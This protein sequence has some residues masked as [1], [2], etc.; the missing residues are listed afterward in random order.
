VERQRQLAEQ[1]L[2]Q[3]RA[4]GADAADVILGEGTDFSVTVR[5]GEVE[6]LEDAGSKALGLRVFVG[7]RTANSYTSDFSPAAL[8]ELVRETVE[9]ARVTGEDPAAGL[10]DEVVPAEELDL[11]LFDPSPAALPTAERIDWARRAEAA[12]LQASPEITNSQGGSYSSGEDVL[13]LGNTAGFLGSYRTSSV[14]FSV[15]PVAERDGRMERDY[16]Y[17]AGRGL[18]ELPSPEEVGRIA[19]ERTLR[20]LGARQVATAEVPVVFDPETAAELLGHVFRALSGY[21]VFRSATFLKDSL[22][23]VVASPLVTVVDEG[24]RPRGLGSRPFDGEG[25]PTRRNV[26][27]EKGVLRHF[28]CDS[29]S[30]RKIGARPTG[31]ARRGVAG[32]PTV[33]SSNLYLE[34]GPAAPEQILGE[35][36]RGLYVTDLI[37]FGVDLV[38]GDFSQGAVGHWIEKGRLVHPVSEV[39]IAGNLRQ[40]LPDIDAVGSDLVFRGSSAAPTLRV[41]KMTVSGS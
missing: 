5:K 15:V 33:G 25:L 29:Y 28:L 26:P 23:E 11:G 30:A 31:S 35:V 39:T 21:A 41:K 32:G 20:R 12:A 40:M 1:L 13:V 8:A 18:S 22:G 10:P 9:M 2:R 17:A 36:E 4:A 27:I 3:A 24:R 37:G 14:S 6:T 19:A 7:K 16:W 38:S 34:P